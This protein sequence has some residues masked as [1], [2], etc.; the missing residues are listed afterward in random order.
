MDLDFHHHQKLNFVSSQT[1][2]LAVNKT[3]MFHWEWRPVYSICQTILGLVG[4]HAVARVD[5]RGG[6]FG[7]AGNQHKDAFAYQSTMPMTS[8]AVWRKT[9]CYLTTIFF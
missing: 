5:K 6:R 7:K 3:A 4:A 1:E 9:R 2:V 8:I